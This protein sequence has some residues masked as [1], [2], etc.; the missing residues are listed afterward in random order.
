VVGFLCVLGVVASAQSAKPKAKVA[1]T[2]TSDDVTITATEA[3]IAYL[4]EKGYDPDFGARPLARLIQEE[5]KRPLG[6]ELLF[7]KLEKG[8]AV[9][10]D[11]KDGKLVF[12]FSE[13]GSTSVA[14]AT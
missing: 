14:H 11:A 5:V 1:Y 12:A 10:V 4:A 3:A 2:I 6:D 9:K 13:T 7:G 8:G